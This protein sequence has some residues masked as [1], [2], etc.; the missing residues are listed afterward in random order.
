[1]L[2]AAHP[3]RVERVCLLD[4]AIGLAERGRTGGGRGDPADEGWATEQEAYDAR[5]AGR[6]EQSRA[7]V[8]QDVAEALERGE[9]G[10]YR[11]RFCRSA[12]VTAW[13]EMT[14]PPV[15]LAA[16]PGELLLVTAARNDYVDD[17]LRGAL[18]GDLGDRFREAPVDA[19]HM[20]YW[21]AFDQ[22]VET[23]RPF[24]VRS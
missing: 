8:E 4:P 3:E 15:S 17:R 1:M 16:W 6:P 2:A 24:L 5:L 18:R 7:M 12:A 10:R 20:V 23:I 13:G 22:L 11:M 19:G 9:D 21:E 14:A